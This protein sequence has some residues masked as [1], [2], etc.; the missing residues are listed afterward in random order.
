[1]DW[2]LSLALDDIDKLDAL[3]DEVSKVMLRK[4]LRT[5]VLS[6]FWGLRG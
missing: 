3:I 2:F 6:C 1:M 4:R 5:L